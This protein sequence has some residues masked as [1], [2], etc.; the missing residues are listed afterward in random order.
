MPSGTI[1]RRSGRAGR[2]LLGILLI[3]LMA[4]CFA[5]LDTTV[6]HLGT[7]SQIPVVALLWSRYAIQAA[8]MGLWL[9]ALQMRRGRSLFRV[10]H[11]RFQGLRGLL[12]LSTSVFGFLGVQALPVA[13]FTAVALL[14][15]VV[16][17]LISAL[18][19]HERVSRGR[20]ALVL[21]G[22]SGAL[23]ILRPGS[24]LF[25]AAILL[26]LALAFCNGTF[27]VLTARLAALEHPLTT[28]FYTGLIG[29]LLMTAVLWVSPVEIRPVLAA[30]T[31]GQ[32]AQLALV[33]LMGTVGHLLLILALGLAPMALLMPF[34]YAQIAVATVI[35][36]LVFHHFPD[37]WAL[38]G[39]AVIAACG[40]GAVWLN[41]KEAARRHTPSSVVAAD[42]VPE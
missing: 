21:G 25:G 18:V 6:K 4:L 19:L 28:H 12:L 29:A 34:S 37:A 33:G 1:G 39:M 27:Q 5:T 30:A 10:A 32:L 9:L 17:T 3:L 2:P 11:P 15:P 14:A 40:A 22:F 41:Q 16:V 20:W 23:L 26:P 31:P 24:G 8:V 35:S 13:E 38:G 42:A 36:S 7:H